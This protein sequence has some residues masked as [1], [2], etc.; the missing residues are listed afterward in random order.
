MKK[1]YIW[2]M[3]LLVIIAG[4]VVYFALNKPSNT[5]ANMGITTPDK[6]VISW[7]N[8]DAFWEAVD[9]H[10]KSDGTVDVAKFRTQYKNA[11]TPNL[12]EYF[13]RV[14]GSVD[15]AVAQSAAL[16]P[17]YQSYRSAIDKN[18]VHKT[19]V[20]DIYA[21]LFKYLPTTTLPRTVEMVVGVFNNDLG[22]TNTAV[23]VSTDMF[24]KGINVAWDRL[25]YDTQ[26]TDILKSAYYPYAPTTQ[27]FT[28][29]IA[30]LLA[31]H[32]QAQNDSSLQDYENKRHANK[33]IK[34]RYPIVYEGIAEFLQFVLTGRESDRVITGDTFADK[35]KNGGFS[36]QYTKFYEKSHTSDAHFLARYINTL[37]PVQNRPVD[38]GH[39]LGYRIAKNYWWRNMDKS[40]AVSDLINPKNA[41]KIFQAAVF[42]ST[43]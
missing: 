4:G 26:K 3:A 20:Q 34:V 19:A 27:G 9:T 2:C 24:Y 36:T 28:D 8:Y 11:I 32:L 13:T 41:D 12:A 25:P 17:F 31:H 6:V 38:Y 14:Y 37:T 16:I 30:Y 7:K 43:F 10:T 21:K 23:I 29:S 5:M 35:A 18:S 42:Y 33:G 40:K 1:I 15:T 39:W 22:I